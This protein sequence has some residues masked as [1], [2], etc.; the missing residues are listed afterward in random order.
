[1]SNGQ[2][3][4]SAR[5]PRKPVNRRDADC[6]EKSET[7]S[8]HDGRKNPPTVAVAI[9]NG[10]SRGK[11]TSVALIL[12]SPAGAVD[13][14]HGAPEAE[15][16]SSR[17]IL[18]AGTLEKSRASASGAACLNGGYKLTPWVRIL[19]RRDCKDPASARV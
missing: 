6:A 7:V 2:D 11:T 9:S 15:D 16:K 4:D 12:A 17:T 1:L 18:T 5:K 19:L 3:A 10:L 13:T 8:E 14:Y